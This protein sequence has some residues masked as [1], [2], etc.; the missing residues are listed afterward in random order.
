MVSKTFIRC[1]A[2]PGVLPGS[3]EWL[4]EVGTYD[5]GLWGTANL[6]SLITL[7]K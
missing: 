3:Q 7:N 6:I 5:E 2:I 1:E 4:T